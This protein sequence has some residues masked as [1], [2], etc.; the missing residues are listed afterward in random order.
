M[1]RGAEVDS[2]MAKCIEASNVNAYNAVLTTSFQPMLNNSPTVA[3]LVAE[4]TC[5]G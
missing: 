4:R 5:I 3:R 1:G 2:S